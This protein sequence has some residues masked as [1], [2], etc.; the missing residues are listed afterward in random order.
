MSISDDYHIY[1]EE[2]RLWETTNWLGVNIQKNPCDLL[3]IQELIFNIKPDLIIETGSNK[4]GSALFFASLCELI[5]HG[6]VISVDINLEN[7]QFEEIDKNTFGERIKFISGKSVDPKTVISV[8]KEIVMNG[9]EKIIVFLD[10]WHSEDYVYEE[11]EIYKHFVSENSYLVV[12]DTHIFNP[13]VWKHKDLGPGRAVER[14]LLENKNFIQDRKCERLSFTF[15]PGGFLLKTS[16][17]IR[18]K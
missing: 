10:S 11:I 9:Y 15:N 14:F 6:N 1:Y 7:V 12:E 13:I 4:G 2:N 8:F 16:N 17:S 18:E 5:G 3:I